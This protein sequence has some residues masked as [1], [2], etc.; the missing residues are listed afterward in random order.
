[1]IMLGMTVVIPAKKQTT[2]EDA[3]DEGA[4]RNCDKDNLALHKMVKPRAEV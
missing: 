1:M 2:E 4:R 3:D